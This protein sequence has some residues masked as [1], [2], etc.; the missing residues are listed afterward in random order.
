VVTFRQTD[1]LFAIDLSNPRAPQILGALHIPG[2]SEYMHPLG[3]THLLTV[4]RDADPN[5]GWSQNLALQVFDVSDRL[6][7]QLAHKLVFDSYGGSA[8]EY[9]H[10]AFTFFA[11]RQLLAIPYAME[12][13]DEVNWYR[14]TSSMELFRV[15]AQAGITPLGSLSGDPLLSDAE[16]D[17]INWVCYPYY[18]GSAMGS[19]FQRG[20]FMDDVI[21]GVARDGVV[22]AKVAEPSVPL[23]VMQL[24]DPS[25]VPD[26]CYSNGYG[27]AGG[28][29]GT[30]GS[31]GGIGGSGGGEW[32][33]GTGGTGGSEW[34]GGTGGTAGV[35]G[36]STGGA[37]GSGGSDWD[38]GTAGAGGA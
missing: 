29:G 38:A 19:S 9:D 21:Y 12:V 23:G 25:V 24:A 3:D 31:G 14:M 28:S 2:F 35:G 18:Y 33:A 6:H 13:Y 36:G 32:D 26:Y 30:G 7:P 37:G 16:R 15:D 10:K 20:I 4:G 22:A 5:T 34:D 27:G 8:A 17:P 11:D 1:P